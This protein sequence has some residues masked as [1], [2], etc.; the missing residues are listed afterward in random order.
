MKVSLNWLNEF[1]DLKG[2][3]PAEIM[4]KFS[5]ATAEIDGYE[6]KMPN[7]D[8]GVCAQIKTCKAVPGK[9]LSL[10]TVFDGKKDLQVICGAPNCRVG[11]KVIHANIGVKNIA[12]YDSH[13]MCLSGRE[14]GISDD[15]DGIIELPD[16]A[17]VGQPLSAVLPDVYD[18]IF[19]IGNTAITNRPDLWGHYGIARELSV[20]FGRSLK[21]LSTVDL[22]IYDKLPQIPVTIE[23][24]RDCLSYGAIR[25]DSIKQ[26]TTPLFMQTR[27]FYLGINSHGF[28]VD[29]TNY[30]MLETGQPNHSFDADKMG[31]ISIGNVPPGQE[32]VTLKDQ[33]VKTTPEMLFIKSDGKPVALAGVIGG[34]NS[35]IDARTKNCVFEFATFDAACVRKTA[36]AL[37]LRTD[38]SS[39]FEKALDTN[40]NQM[41]AARMVYL[42]QQHDKAAKVVSAFSRAVSTETQEIKLTLDTQYVEKFC[43]IRF[44]WTAVAIR[45]AGLGF[46]PVLSG[47]ELR[48]IVPTWRATKDVTC[49]ADIIEEIVRTYGI[50]NI[51]PKAPK[52]EVHPVPQLPML[53]LVRKIKDTLA[54]KYGCSEVHTY[55]WSDTQSYMRVVNS[56][57][58]GL[59]WLRSEMAPSVLKVVEKNKADFDDIRIFEI[60]QVYE[61]NG[62]QKH[63]CIVVPDYRELANVLRVLFGC[64]FKLGGAK[65]SYLHPKNNALVTIGGKV[66]GFI[67]AVPTQ[68]TAVAEVNLAALDLTEKSVV[69]KRISKY[70]K[71]TLDFTF[72]TKKAYGVVEEIFEKFIHPLNMGFRLKDVYND[73]FTLQFTVGS[74]DRTLDSTDISD[75]WAKIIEHGR[76]NGLTL[77]QM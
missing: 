20:I 17:P 59:D 14:L 58:K 55:L 16:D 4:S 28:L 43:G 32:F 39:R 40:L 71:N 11:M 36:T 19:E 5:L 61:K 51:V 74:F 48:V 69:A 41:A 10:L 35:E 26:K 6:V 31:K 13:G 77:K 37:G 49:G 52:I 30:I 29:L 3:T 24:K 15:H 9:K 33:T 47:N 63:L 7:I 23:N 21:P 62:E 38:A 18:T 53:K 50:D 46:A 65:Q 67:G 68:N 76:K 25:V 70:Q 45:L 22:S 2:I 56:C 57:I 42:I 72:V 60:A 12:G 1:V 54:N 73:S 44:G 75:I 64:R 27:L 66:V 8:G 34:K